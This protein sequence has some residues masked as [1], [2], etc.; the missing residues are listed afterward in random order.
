MPASMETRTSHPPKEVVGAS[1]LLGVS[2]LLGILRAFLDGDTEDLASFFVF[3]LVFLAISIGVAFGIYRGV[4]WLR[5]LCALLIVLG[6]LMTPFAMNSITSP[7]DGFLYACQTVM[8][9][10]AT[11]L[12]FFPRSSAWFGRGAR[13]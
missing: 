12:M 10:V 1:L 5:W 2:F 7:A 8:Q 4:N 3:V 13:A 11:C 6:L 9:G